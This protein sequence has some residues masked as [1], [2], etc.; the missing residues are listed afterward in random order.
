MFENI[1]PLFA[2]KPVMIGL[3]KVDILKRAELK[4]EKAELLAK[5]ESDSVQICELSTVTQEGISEF[6]NKVGSRNLSADFSILIY[7]SFI[8]FFA[9]CV[10]F[11]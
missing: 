10:Y 5:L 7:F 11:V 2:N 1:R 8:C 4:S 3:N 6:K 9:F